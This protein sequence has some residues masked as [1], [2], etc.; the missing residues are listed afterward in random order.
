[1]S[2]LFG[3]G[4]PQWVG[5]D[6][7]PSTYIN[8]THAKFTDAQFQQPDL[9]DQQSVITGVRS[10]EKRVDDDTC[11]YSE[12]T[13]LIYLRKYADPVSAFNT[14]YSYLNEWVYFAPFTTPSAKY[15]K[16]VDDNLVK[17]YVYSIAPSFLD[18]TGSQD[19]LTINIKSEKYTDMNNTIN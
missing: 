12:F 18:E 16:D 4:N 7:N 15:I 5:V 2:S 1:M 11:N 17:F 9:L 6:L 19:I 13:M 14:L 3:T 8:L 10:F